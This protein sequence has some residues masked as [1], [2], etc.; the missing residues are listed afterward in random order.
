MN[1]KDKITN[2]AAILAVLGG[3]VNAYLQTNAGKPI[4]W[5]ELGGLLLL[6]GISYLT[7]KDAEGKTKT[8]ELLAKQ[9][10]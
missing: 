3:V 8:P 5:A 9:V 1:F 7:G 6:A 10:K 4:D 2:Y